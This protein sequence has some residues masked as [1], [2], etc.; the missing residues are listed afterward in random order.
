MIEG[1]SYVLTEKKH[2]DLVPL[3]HFISLQ[4]VFYLLVPGLALLL[5][6]AHTA[7]HLADLLYVRA[8]SRID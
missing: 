4:L 6:C 7:T 1:I 8:R 5:F 3:H 2:L